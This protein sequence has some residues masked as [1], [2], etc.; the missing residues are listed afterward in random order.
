MKT[1]VCLKYSVNDCR[2]KLT[3]K[4]STQPMKEMRKCIPLNFRMKTL[5]SILIL[6]PLRS[7]RVVDR[8]R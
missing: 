1:R 2:A 4:F 7:Y 8:I 3:I 6:H 5:L